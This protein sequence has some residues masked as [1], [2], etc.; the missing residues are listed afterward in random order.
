[1]IFLKRSLY[2]VPEGWLV[3]ETAPAFAFSAIAFF[4]FLISRLDL[5]WPLDMQTPEVKLR[6]YGPTERF[7]RLGNYLEPVNGSP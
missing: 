5:F 2:D 3:S 7:A 4:G 6:P 1:M